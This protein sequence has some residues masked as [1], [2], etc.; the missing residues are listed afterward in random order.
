MPGPGRERGDVPDGICAMTDKPRSD[1][2]VVLQI[3][4]FYVGEFVP[5]LYTLAGCM[6]HSRVADLRRRGYQ[7]ECKR[8]GRG[9]YRY[10]LVEAPRS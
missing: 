3:L 1:A 5:H 10:R 4:R 6:V 8:F 7:I 9:D 2:D